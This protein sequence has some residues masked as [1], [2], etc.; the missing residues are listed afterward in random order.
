MRVVP[1]ALVV[2]CVC[3]L[4]ALPEPATLAPVEL[5][6]A[7]DTA[8]LALAA[9]CDRVAERLDELA[10]LEARMRRVAEIERPDPV[11]DVQPGPGHAAML[12]ELEAHARELTKGVHTIEGYHKRADAIEAWHVVAKHTTDT[13]RKSQALYEAAMLSD[14]WVAADLFRDVIETVGLEDELGQIA[15]R[16]LGHA[17]NAMGNM[18]TAIRIWLQLADAPGLSDEL[19][20][21]TR[22]MVGCY[23]ITRRDWTTA[24]RVL[25]GVADDFMNHPDPKIRSRA[26]AAGRM[27]KHTREKY[28]GGN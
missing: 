5:P 13:K 27:A 10:G 26:G 3:C 25:Q 24:A 17:E 21:H 7:A 14:W 6:R 18:D 28:L 20:M 23:S 4:V 8:A 16:Q 15:A 2:A 11:A 19:A 1:L 9:R 12:D 22:Y